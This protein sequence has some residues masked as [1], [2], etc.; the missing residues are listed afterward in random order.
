MN[1]SSNQH[2]G[3]KT[4]PAFWLAAWIMLLV[5]L[6]SAAPTGGQPRTR[7]VGSAFDPATFSVLVAPKKPR[8]ASSVISLLKG[9]RSDERAGVAPMIASAL[10]L[11]AAHPYPLTLRNRPRFGSRPAA[12]F[13]R[14]PF[15]KTLGPRAPPAG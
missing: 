11:S 12:A 3:R 4:Q 1:A 10:G 6:L 9:K 5:V 15:P 7:F 14:R 8:F 13:G 2:K